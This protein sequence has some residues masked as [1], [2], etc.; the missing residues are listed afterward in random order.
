MAPP[1]SIQLG[2]S[3]VAGIAFARVNCT[4]TRPPV[5]T[6]WLTIASHSTAVIVSTAPSGWM[7]APDVT[8][9]PVTGATYQG[10]CRLPFGAGSRPLSVSTGSNISA[11]ISASRS[12]TPS[13]GRQRQPMTSIVLADMPYLGKVTVPTSNSSSG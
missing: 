7:S 1:C 10:D 5:S 11:V 6:A 9:T 3:P 13:V 4:S 8:S 12:C 2:Q